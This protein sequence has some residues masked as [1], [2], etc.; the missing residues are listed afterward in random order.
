MAEE[1]QGAEL[2]VSPEEER[3]L[4]RFFRR[5]LRPYLLLMAV[6]AVTAMW[7]WPAGGDTARVQANA[8]KISGVRAEGERLRA[9]VAALAAR[10]ETKLTS[11]DRGGDEL[12]RRV[13]DARHSVRMIE[14]RITAALD[15]R[16]DDLE[17]RV[18][19]S[20]ASR[21]SFGAPP[22]EA[23]SWD[24]GAILDRL[25]NLEM[26]QENEKRSDVR[27]IARLEE[28]LLRLEGQLGMGSIPAAPA[29]P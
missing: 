1:P 22:P 2:E 7:W 3:F 19:K 14:S 26:R 15:R 16:L 18:A 29:D 17:S 5:E 21:T 6:I 11:S 9:E 24:V 13:R 20:G 23:A 8:A 12:E 4:R 10:L 25:Y 28:R 27:R